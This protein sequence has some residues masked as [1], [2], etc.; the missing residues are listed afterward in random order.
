MIQESK[1]SKV[2]LVLTLLCAGNLLGWALL[3]SHV[4]GN[5]YREFHSG[6]LPGDW[7]G[8]V[9]S[10]FAPAIGYGGADPHLLWSA[11]DA[12]MFSL[13]MPDTA[14]RP[15]ILTS[16]GLLGVLG[17]LVGAFLL[18]GARL[19]W[20]RGLALGVVAS[21][22]AWASLDRTW[23]AST[24]VTL[25]RLVLGMAAAPVVAWS[26]GRLWSGARVLRSRDVAAWMKGYL[27]AA[28]VGALVVA[29]I[30]AATLGIFEWGKSLRARAYQ[31]SHWAQAW[32]S[33]RTV[34]ASTSE[35]MGVL[36]VKIGPWYHFSSGEGDGWLRITDGGGEPS[37]ARTWWLVVRPA[38]TVD[39]AASRVVRPDSTYA[40]GRLAITETSFIIMS[41]IPSPE[42]F[43][44]NQT[45]VLSHV[46]K[47]TLAVV[48]DDKVPPVVS[49]WCQRV[50]AAS[51][52]TPR[53]ASIGHAS[54]FAVAHLAAF[55][56]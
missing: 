22:A 33:V 48:E 32:A 26:L 54:R 36:R 20:G 41:A 55:R 31:L 3:V 43:G 1:H 56:P 14:A 24:L 44:Q 17:V 38:G 40:E 19:T 52:S 27:P 9:Y 46:W 49:D 51:P 8:T 30:L 34:S 21:L 7:H 15:F 11:A 23:E 25:G 4:R 6:T 16:L 29:L 10:A 53:A 47:P 5:Y 28:C 39:A 50:A 13:G 35:L 45:A 37:Q 2:W 42:I 18:Y 12:S